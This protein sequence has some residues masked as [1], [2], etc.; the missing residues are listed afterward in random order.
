MT[1]LAVIPAKAGIQESNMEDYSPEQLEEAR[2]IFAGPCD[3]MWGSADLENLPPPTRGE[4]ALAGRSNV[5]KS[6]LVNALTGRKTLAKVSDTPGRT[7]Q[8]NFFALGEHLYLVDMPG[9][10]YAKVSKDTRTAWDSL[11]FDYLR[12]RVTL[13]C[14]LIMVDSR[15]GLKESDRDLMTLLDKAALQY[16]I[17]LTKA[18]KADKN[19]AAMEESITNEL[20]KHPAAYPHIYKTSAHKNQGLEQLRAAIISLR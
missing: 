14:V 17:I 5:G 16:R 20:K 4:I 11:I 18:D 6:S 2:K 19:T 9:Y 12:G 8:L 3:F 10:G 7:Q 15:H 1:A 13:R